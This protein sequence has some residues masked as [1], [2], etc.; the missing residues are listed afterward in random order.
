LTPNTKGEKVQKIKL[1]QEKFSFGKVL[2]NYQ[3]N[4][5]GIYNLINPI[6][7]Y[8]KISGMRS[9]SKGFI[10]QMSMLSFC[11]TI[12]GVLNLLPLPGFSVGNFII[13]FVESRRGKVFDLKKKN[14]LGL[15]TILI[16]ILVILFL[17]F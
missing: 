7:D 17:R 8:K 1:A 4:I 9:V 12:I 3:N 14:I 6:K 15:S 10:G 2:E 13:S 16:V 11:S 5:K